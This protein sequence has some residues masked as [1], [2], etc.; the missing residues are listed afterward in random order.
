MEF[1][2]IDLFI[3]FGLVGFFLLSKALIYFYDA[4]SRIEQ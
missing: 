1:V 2:M 3:V 4:I